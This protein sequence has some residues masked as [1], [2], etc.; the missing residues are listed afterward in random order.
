MR[1]LDCGPQHAPAFS[2]DTDILAVLFRK[3]APEL[4]RPQ[5]LFMLV[6]ERFAAFGV[7]FGLLTR[8]RY[9]PLLR[10]FGQLLARFGR[11]ITRP[12]SA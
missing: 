1:R 9:T 6:S 12:L 8:N 10:G 4:L 3:D 2:P 5:Q 7:H 11:R